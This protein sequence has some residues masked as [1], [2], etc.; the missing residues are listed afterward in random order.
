MI[1]SKLLVIRIV[2]AR[3][4]C[5]NRMS[6]SLLN[7][8]RCEAL[9]GHANMIGWRWH[10]TG[11]KATYDAGAVGGSALHDVS[12]AK[13]YSV[14]SPPRA[15]ARVG[16]NSPFPRFARSHPQWSSV[17]T[18]TTINRSSN[19]QL[20]SQYQTSASLLRRIWHKS[21]AAYLLPFHTE[22]GARKTL[23]LLVQE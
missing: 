13:I 20:S 6:E 1:R 22:A 23:D 8:R 16:C 7:Q 5:K 3:S 14:A 9:W 11:T 15:R 12:M 17:V 19:S 4:H 18:R 21:S 10:W 2:Q